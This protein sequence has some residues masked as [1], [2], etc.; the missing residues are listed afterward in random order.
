M[1]VSQHERLLQLL[2]SCLKMMFEIA[3]AEVGLS[4]RVLL[5]SYEESA[6]PVYLLSFG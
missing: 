1:L 2:N 3:L 4:I 6:F 5:A